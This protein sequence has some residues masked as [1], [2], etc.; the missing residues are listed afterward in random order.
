MYDI[1]IDELIYADYAHAFASGYL[2]LTI[3]TFFLHPPGY[4]L[5]LSVWR[6]IFWHGHDIFAQLTL[7]R[8]F[9]ILLSGFTALFIVLLT[10]LVTKK[11]NLAIVAGALFALDPLAIRHNTRGLMETMTM[12]LV[13]IGVWLLFRNTNNSESGRKTWL[14]TGLLFGFA[15]VT[16][17]VAAIFLF[18]AFVIM[19]LRNV[20][21]DHKVFRYIIPTAILPY[22]IWVSFITLTGHLGMFIFDKTLGL[23]R[24]FGLVQITGF[25][26]S[27]APS[28]NDTLFSTL[29]HY[30]SSY[31]IMGLGALGMLLLLKSKDKDLRR[32]GC[33]AAASIMVIG[34]LII[35]GTFEEQF[36]YY[37]LIPSFITIAVVTVELQKLIPSTYR[38]FVNTGG[39]LGMAILLLFG[40]VTYV[41]NMSSPDNGWQKTI[42]WVDANVPPNSTIC[43]F[44]QGE[45]L[46]KGHGFN[47]CSWHS[48]SDINAHHVQYIIDPEKLTQANYVALSTKDIADIKPESKVVFNY[49]SRDSGKF[50][51]LEL[52]KFAISSSSSSSKIQNK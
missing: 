17:D 3:E 2:P 32:W 47:L 44:E 21:P 40:A 10:K 1:H 13:L 34:Y 38:Y 46:L 31:I 52:S 11:T 30:A 15:I 7:L 18:I 29:P 19:I 22:S 39:R 35:G 36:L 45:T 20:G 6:T 25:N 50:L 51:I 41:V 5:L 8:G 9:N 16:K 14:L 48:L 12:L 49:T 43:V 42:E 37:L 27:S 33:I 26:S 23:R 4:Y 28:R 24:F